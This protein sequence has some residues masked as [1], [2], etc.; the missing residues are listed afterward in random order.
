MSTTARLR[1][2]VPP[3]RI[4]VSESGIRTPEDIKK[5]RCWGVNAALVGETL[6]SSPDIA[7]KMRELL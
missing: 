6:L 7:A 2:L 5:L 4:V 1:P 3:D